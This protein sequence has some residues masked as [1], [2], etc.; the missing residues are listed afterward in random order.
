MKSKINHPFQT[1]EGFFESLKKEMALEIKNKS[2][3]QIP[4]SRRIAMVV[5]KYAAIIILSF[6]LGRISITY[7]NH[8]DQLAERRDMYSVEDVFSQ[9][10]VDD[11]TDF[12]IQNGSME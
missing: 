9:V 3:I 11:I 1:P 4:R 8:Q 7:F 12:L 5:L 6:F 10:S 2:Q